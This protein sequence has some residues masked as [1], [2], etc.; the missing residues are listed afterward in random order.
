MM[1]R[2]YDTQDAQ[3]SS[4]SILMILNIH[5]KNVTII[6]IVGEPNEAKTFLE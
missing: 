2:F 4:F 6:V 1:I 5:Y 3:R